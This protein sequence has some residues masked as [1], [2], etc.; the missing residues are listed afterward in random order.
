MN[1]VIEK[2]VGVIAGIISLI[3]ILLIL[4]ALFDVFIKISTV[5]EKYIVNT[6]ILEY[7]LIAF[8]VL[9]IISWIRASIEI[10]WMLH[11]QREKRK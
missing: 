7:I 1:K 9:L 8:I 5:W 6:K 10:C 2:S 3:I 11:Q 4:N